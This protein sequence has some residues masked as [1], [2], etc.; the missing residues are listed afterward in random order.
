MRLCAICRR[1]PATSFEH[2]PGKAT[3]NRG[4]ILVRYAAPSDDGE[5]RFEHRFA[6]YGDGF[7]LV[8]LCAKYNQNTGSRDGGAYSSFVRQFGEPGRVE[9]GTGAHTLG[10]R[11]FRPLRVIKQ[12]YSMF[13]SVQLERGTDQWDGLREFVGLRDGTL[14]GF[15]FPRVYLYRNTADQGRI[16]PLGALGELFVPGPARGDPIVCSEI[17]WPPLGVVFALTRPDY[18]SAMADV[19]DW[20]RAR[21]K[22]CRSEVLR[23]PS[24]RVE[25]DWPLGFGSGKDVDDW[26][27][28]MG[29][30]WFLGSL[31]DPETPN[32]VSMTLR[33][34]DSQG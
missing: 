25:T 18:F 21:F 5:A 23:V 24:Y 16:C 22:D 30:V 28:R 3:R 7:G 20:G 9:P 2:L 19:T 4:K 1:R 31:G 10:I 13:L 8:S 27:D 26:I 34:Q 15:E 33:R 6:E 11:D 12:L 29:V 17:A 14:G 32:S